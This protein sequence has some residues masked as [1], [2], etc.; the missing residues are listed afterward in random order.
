MG[1]HFL[2]T[3]ALVKLYRTEP[4]TQAVQAC[5][6][7]NDALVLSGL[8]FLEFQSAFF[9]LVRQKHI[10]TV[11]AQQRIALL[12]QDFGNFEIIPLS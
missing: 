6:K 10:S 8:A 1:R 3:S 2:D 11:D 9:G 7:P 5:I 4:Q 12:Q